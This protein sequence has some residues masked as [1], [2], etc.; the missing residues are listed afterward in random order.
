MPNTPR[1]P[2][3]PA[4]LCGLST[5]EKLPVM[6]VSLIIPPPSASSALPAKPTPSEVPVLV[7]AVL[8]ETTLPDMSSVPPVTFMPA[9]SAPPSPFGSVAMAVFFEITVFSTVVV[10]VRPVTRTPPV[11]ATRFWTCP[12]N[13]AGRSVLRLAVLPEITLSLMTSTHGRSRS[14]ARS[15]GRRPRCRRLRRSAPPGWSPSLGYPTRSR[16]PA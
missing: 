13:S 16:D 11:L 1:A 15:P 12:P 8:P 9:S 2:A 10:G 3:T 5:E 14:P 7:I 4:A 6:R